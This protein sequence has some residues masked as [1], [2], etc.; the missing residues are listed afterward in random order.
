MLL[1]VSGLRRREFG[2]VAAGLGAVA[3]AEIARSILLANGVFSSDSWLAVMSEIGLVLLLLG[4]V[5]AMRGRTNTAAESSVDAEAQA[6]NDWTRGLPFLPFVTVGVALLIALIAVSRGYSMTAVGFD[7]GVVLI[8]LLLLAQQL[9][10]NREL[11]SLN[12]DLRKSSELFE[13]LVVGSS[14]LITLH[15]PDGRLKYASPAV[16]RMLDMEPAE[17][18][19]KPLSFVVHPD[20]LPK[21]AKAHEELRRDPSATAQLDLRVGRPVP[22]VHGSDA[23][24][25]VPMWRWVDAVAHNLIEDGAV[26]GIVCNTRDIHEQQLLRQ[27]L[28]YE[29]YH[30]TLTGLGNLALARRIFAEQCYGPNRAPVTLVLADLDGFKRSMTRSGTPLVTTS[31]WQSLAESD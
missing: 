1:R 30:D 2:L 18:L 25:R 29:A 6:I 22:D 3:V 11:A 27:R 26:H 24:A 15:E 16:F 14:D 9:T 19:G 31:W 10:S 20:D 12:N 8:M 13:S 23:S 21:L 28:S 7:S 17:L 4:G 5:A